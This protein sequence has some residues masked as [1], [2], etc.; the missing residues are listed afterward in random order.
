MSFAD[1]LG[2]TLVGKN[3]EVK[4]E[5]AVANKK[6]IALYFSAHWC[7]PCRGF[8]PTLAKTYEEELKARG[9]EVVFVSSDQDAEAWKEYF[10]EMPWLSLPFEAKE[11]KESL[12]K[13]Y[14]IRGIPTLIILDSAG[15]LVAA[16]GRAR[17]SDVEALFKDID[18]SS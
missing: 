3:G 6:A 11:L 13:K 16:D 7:P 8:T 10:D 2:A 15:K 9:M 5:D 17:I 14:D 4:T 12:S 18:A 1:L